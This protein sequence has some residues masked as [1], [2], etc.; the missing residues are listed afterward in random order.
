M[1]KQS[2]T[3]QLAQDEQN[4]AKEKA[5]IAAAEEDKGAG[6]GDL[7]VAEKEVKGAKEALSATRSGCM[8]VA[9]DHEF[10][11]Q[12]RAEE[13]KV[14]KEAI[15]TLVES[16]S[17]AQAQTY[18][19]VQVATSSS[20]TSKVQVK[21]SNVM[22]MVNQLAKKHHSLALSQLA[23]RIKSL[24]QFGAQSGD[25]PFGKVKTLIQDLISKL[26][27][28]AQEEAEEKAYCDEEMAKTK[29]KKEELAG[30]IAKLKSK[31]DTAS[32]RAEKLTDEVSELQAALARLAKEQEEMDKVR[33]ESHSQYL[34]AKANNEQGI[35]GIRRAMTV[36]REYYGSKAAGFLQDSKEF[37]DL[38]QQP[39]PPVSHSKSEGAGSSIIQIL[40]L[41]E[42]DIAKD[43]AKEE[44]EEADAQA[45][46]EK[47][48]HETKLRVVTMEQDIKYKSQEISAL[49]KSI[50]D[51][52]ADK[53]NLDTELAA[54]NQYWAK[55]TERC[56]AKPE[57]Y[58]ERKKRRDAEIAGLKEALQVLTDETA[59]VQRRHRGGSVRGSLIQ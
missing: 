22:R 34:E 43:L 26:E 21:A 2:L 17:G 25:D 46:Y 14:I 44:T 30:D 41:A 29:E 27:T 47:I 20:M 54:V 57:Q 6:V 4:M 39:S 51:L 28:E 33:T 8:K 35:A 11:M 10:S 7:A 32:S 59:F 53:E 12:A 38:L 15:K 3:D 36:L 19:F 48:T 9:G 24:L 23:S 31:I 55:L 18:S 42:T 45:E 58:A 50:S 16:T 52:S 56:I 49:Q 1:L 40:E 37:A 13:V 5:R